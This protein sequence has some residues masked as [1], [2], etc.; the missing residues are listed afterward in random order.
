MMALFTVKESLPLS[1]LF[2]FLSGLFLTLATASTQ[3]PAHIDVAVSNHEKRQQQEE[4]EDENDN[5]ESFVD[6]DNVRSSTLD[7]EEKLKP[8]TLKKVSHRMWKLAYAMNLFFAALAGILSLVGTWFG[9]I[10]L[11]V[12]L[13]QISQILSG[14]VVFSYILQTEPKPNK[15]TSVGNYIIVLSSIMLIFVGPEVKGDPRDALALLLEPRAQLLGGGL[16]IVG[17]VFCF[18]YQ[19][20]LGCTNVRPDS[21]YGAN[22]A[23][24]LVTEVVHAVI[25]NN[26][27]KLFHLLTGK[28]FIAN[29]V[30]LVLS[31]FTI[32]YSSVLRSTIIL[33]QTNYIPLNVSANIFLNGVVGLVIWEDHIIN[34]G[35]YTVL[36]FFFLMG[37]YLVSSYEIL[38]GTFLKDHNTSVIER[39][40]YRQSRN[41]NIH[42][43]IRETE[44]RSAGSIN[45]QGTTA[46]EDTEH[47]S[48]YDQKT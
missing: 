31:I 37:V 17:Y 28:Y 15:E 1:I 4:E 6:D 27:S 26:C 34:I 41:S 46:R 25:G 22:Y 44:K 47:S 5:V 40:L 29:A 20:I 48:V 30:I 38:P 32:T 2:A 9:P 36:Y 16:L 43:S 42:N 13:K 14:M 39:L 18:P 3:L 24:L 7:D 19:F 23:G 21:N 33:N 35:G 11:F 10:S 12:P 8:T 45:M